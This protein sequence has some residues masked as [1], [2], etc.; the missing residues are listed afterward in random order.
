M[1]KENIFTGA[2]FLHHI[3]VWC[4][5]KMCHGSWTAFWKRQVEGSTSIHSQFMCTHGKEMGN[6]SQQKELEYSSQQPN[7]S[8]RP[9]AE[10]QTDAACS[11]LA[12]PL[13]VAGTQQTC[14]PGSLDRLY[15][16]EEHDL[17]QCRPLLFTV[18]SVLS[19]EAYVFY[20][21][22]ISIYFEIIPVHRT[23]TRLAHGSLLSDSPILSM[24][25]IC[26]LS[27]T[28]SFYFPSQILQ[29]LCPKNKI[30]ILQ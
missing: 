9:E 28:L 1:E 17:P 27:V 10:S 6:V 26:S 22:T 21:Q 30:N 15:S 2:E 11:L 18:G 25:H 24:L 29:L 3:S 13:P 12:N 7:G 4:Q 16:R 19:E 23:F 20:K 14:Q 5:S 8:F